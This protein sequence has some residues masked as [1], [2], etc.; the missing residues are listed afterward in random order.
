MDDP[1][2]LQDRFGIPGAVRI[3]RGAGG[4]TRVV[5]DTPAAAAHV[6]LHGAHVTHYQP[7]GS[8][9]VLFMSNKSYFH[10]GKP[11]RGGVP[12]IF[13]WFGGRA[14]NP[15]APAHGVARTEAWTL[16]EISKQGDAVAVTLTLGPT[17]ASRKWWPHDFGLKCTVTVGA[18]LEMSLEVRNAS[19]DAFIFEEALH[20]YLAVADVRRVTIEGLTGRT[21]RDKMAG[22]QRKLQGPE[23]IRIEGE[24]DRVY[25]DTADTVS[26][27]DVAG[28]R[29]L[30]V[31]KHGSNSTVVWNPWVQKSRA[32]PDIGDEEW[33]GMVCV[34]TANAVENAVTLAAG[35]THMMRATVKVSMPPSP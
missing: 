14:N 13:P 8:A 34:E 11:I 26:V 4:L 3:E 1:T 5:V 35:A 15:M 7:R 31:S 16:S 29:T 19:R 32:M 6:Y 21:Y 12:V 27:S 10:A 2:T 30:S 22:M 24:T 23:A 18:A 28:G 33:P 20:T 17:E 9:P 25:L